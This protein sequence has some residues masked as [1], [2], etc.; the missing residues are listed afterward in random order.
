MKSK[1]VSFVAAVISAFLFAYCSTSPGKV[2][3]K[4]FGIPDVGACK[5]SKDNIDCEKGIGG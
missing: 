3:P 5:A 2:N 1:L 4:D